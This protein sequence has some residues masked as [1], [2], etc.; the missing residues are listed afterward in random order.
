MPIRRCAVAIVV[1]LAAARGAWAED[2][3]YEVPFSGLTITE[4]ELPGAPDQ[5]GW[6]RWNQAAAMWPYV[7]LDEGEGYVD[8]RADEWRNFAVQWRDEGAL[9]I[10]AAAGEDVKGRLFVAKSDLSGMVSLSFVVPSSAASDE[11]ERRFYQSKQRHYSRLVER[12]I[13]GAAWF[14]HLAREA[15]GK[16]HP[17]EGDADRPDVRFSPVRR[18]ATNELEDTYALFS[19]GRAM[20]ENL[21]LDRVLPETKDDPPTVDVDSLRGITVG[22]I[23]WK[24]LMQGLDPAVDPLARHIPADQHAVFFPSFEAA[25]AVA[26][27]LERQG[28]PVLRMVDPRAENAMTR[29]RYERQLGVSLSGLTRLLGPHVVGSVALTGS[30]PYFRTGTDVAVLLESSRPE[31]LQALLLAQIAGMSGELA[32]TGK[33]QGDVDGVRYTAFRSPNREVSSYVAAF[34]GAVVVTNSLAQL[35]QLVRVYK[36]ETRALSSLDEYRFFRNRY[37]LGEAAESGLLF[38]SDA[39]IRRWCSPRWRIATSRRTRDAAVMAEIQAAHFDELVAGTIEAGAVHTKFPLASAGKLRLTA[40]GVGSSVHNTLGFMTPIVELDLRRVTKAEAA[41]YEAWRNRYQQN[42]RWVFDPIALRLGVADEELSADL[43][44]MPLIW[45]SDYRTL[46]DVARGV[47]IGPASGDPHP[48]LAHCILAIN[49]KSETMQGV[50]NFASGMVPALRADPFGWLGPSVSIYCDDDPFWEE[51]QKE[52]TGSDNAERF[53]ENNFDRLPV[54]VYCEVAS[55]LKLT[56]FMAGL[57]AFIEQTSPGMTA[58][59]A[60]AHHDEPYVKVSPTERARGALPGEASPSLYYSFSSDGLL[61][62]MNEA[63][64]QRYIDRVIAR[65]RDKAAG[66]EPPPELSAGVAAWLGSSLCLQVKR[67]LLVAS[68]GAESDRYQAAMQVRSWGNIP[69]LNEWKRRYPRHDPLELQEKFWHTRLECPGGGEYAWNDAWQTMES[70]VYGHPGE[71]KS[72]PAAAGILA[73]V[74]SANFGL[75]FERQ[76]LRAR[77]EVKREKP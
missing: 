51:M 7:S 15:R 69:I 38:L 29:G 62:T 45:S 39:T 66:K 18:G 50:G 64:L 55:A 63:V 48:T 40:A 1:L 34:D 53:M 3:Y 16:V 21:Q 11:A 20:S 49:L 31:P 46:V 37:P 52:A 74:Q 60:S 77:A 68:A 44:V 57:R 23:D 12:N 27:E 6:R 47:E 8:V 22:E 75:S 19:G 59:E 13:P 43:T 5:A 70:T 71:P 24:P 25:V 76:G 17:P 42:W 54:G 10:R 35:R 26:D 41:A 72:G 4:G 30:D 32:R 14:R 67:K 2:A 65:R 28:T 56:A 36:G 58:W 61:L 9:V 33:D 73:D